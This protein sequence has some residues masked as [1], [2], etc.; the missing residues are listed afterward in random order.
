MK[1]C[2]TAKPYSLIL[3]HI[4]SD[5]LAYNAVKSALKIEGGITSLDD[6]WIDCSESEADE[7]LAMARTNFPPFTRE[8]EDAIAHALR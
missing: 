7:I 3:E 8:I 6:F 4:R 1:I 5:N 2:I